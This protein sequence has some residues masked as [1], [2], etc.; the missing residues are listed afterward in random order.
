MNPDA[1][2]NALSWIGDAA[3]S[4]ELG[5]AFMADCDIT[6]KARLGPTASK[7]V[8]RLDESGL[9]R[10][11][12]APEITRH[13]LFVATAPPSD[14]DNLV[15]DAAMIELALS[16]SEP[17]PPVARW[18]ALGDVQLLDD[19]TARWWPQLTGGYSLALDFGSPGAQRIDLSG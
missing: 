6:L 15:T 17:L 5:A 13:L 10:L 18:S 8:N 12:R 9:N 16:G 3:M 11:L 14:F 4:E 19:G 1:V 7:L 2:G